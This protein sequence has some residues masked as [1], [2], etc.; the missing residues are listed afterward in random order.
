MDEQDGFVIGDRLVHRT[1]G[2]EVVVERVE[3]AWCWLRQVGGS[4][5]CARWNRDRLAQSWRRASEA[6]QARLF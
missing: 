5:A 2:N 3:G 6:A 1:L 4:R